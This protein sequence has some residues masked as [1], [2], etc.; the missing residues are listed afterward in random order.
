MYIIST[1][2]GER[3]MIEPI[4]ANKNKKHSPA[5]TIVELLVVIVV[6]AILATITIVSYT[7][8]TKQ[9]TI[10][11]IQSDLSNNSKKLKLYQATYSSYPVAIDSTTKCSTAP[12]TDTAYCLK[13]SGTNIISNYTS[14]GKI[15]SLTETNSDGTIT[16]IV[17][18]GQ[19]PQPKV[20]LAV[21]DPANWLT[22]GNQTW[23]K[24]NLNVGTMVTGVTDQT[25]NSVIEKYCYSDAA[26]NCT[27]YGGLYQW[28][29]AMQY[30]NTESSQGI[31]PAGSHIPSDNDWKILETQLGM[32]Q[33]QVDA[34][35]WRGTNQGTQLQSSSGLNLLLAG[36]R[37]GDDKSFSLMSSHGYLWS[38]SE[39]DTSAWYRGLESG[40]ATFYRY[41]RE[42]TFGFSVR[43]LGN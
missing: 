43:C 25:N 1:I 22:I 24:A 5:F 4:L 14:N 2:D 33:A 8:I 13:A 12:N 3:L 18:D 9:A 40:Y 31:C 27:T 41:T 7:G 39:S 16:Y 19:S 6:I 26:S 23:A 15:F 36:F 34:T 30:T 38:S 35:D 21:S 10:A 37:Y 32:T 29:E 20:S 11:T 17:T 28:D 42:K